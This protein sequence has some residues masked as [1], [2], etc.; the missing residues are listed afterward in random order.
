MQLCLVPLLGKQFICMLPLSFLYPKESRG[1]FNGYSGH[2]ALNI[3]KGY[4]KT[5]G[6]FRSAQ[7]D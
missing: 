6:K 2:T 1:P 4:K 7:M 5:E 3:T